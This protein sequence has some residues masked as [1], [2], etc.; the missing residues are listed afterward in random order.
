VRFQIAQKLQDCTDPHD[1][2]SEP[3]DRARDVADLLL[4]RDLICLEAHVTPA[5][6]ANACAALLDVLRM[7]SPVGPV[8]SAATVELDAAVMSPS[9]P[10]TV[11]RSSSPS[12]APHSSVPVGEEAKV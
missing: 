10:P 2:P 9:G 6:V 4:L 12:F 8:K 5:E 1:P 11:T 3:N 7:T